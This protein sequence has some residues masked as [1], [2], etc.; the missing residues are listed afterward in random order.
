MTSERLFEVLG[1]MDEKYI[2]EAKELPKGKIIRGKDMKK[3]MMSK[4]VIKSFKKPMIAIASLVLMICLT[5]MVVWATAGKQQGF[6]KDITGWD[7]AVIGSVYEQ[8]TEEILLDVDIVDE[9]LIL[10]IK[11]VN[12][13]VI[14]YREFEMFGIRSYEIVDLE[15]NIVKA[16][17]SAEIT[18]VNSGTANVSLLLDQIPA[19]KYQ[20][21]V[22]EMVGSKKADQPLIL[23]GIW[24]CEFV[25][26]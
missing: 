24:V 9:N 21:I 5:G 17:D 18:E 6:F 25:V 15:G 11:M 8:A 22:R 13:E 16:E 26:E 4:H 20:L 2:K 1:D 7:G 23:K 3:R 14:P 10:E 19:G 12:P